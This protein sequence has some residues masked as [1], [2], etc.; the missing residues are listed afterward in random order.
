MGSNP[1]CPSCPSSPALGTQVNAGKKG[2]AMK[3][4]SV[5][6][7]LTIKQLALF[8]DKSSNKT[9]IN[10][11]NFT[12]LNNYITNGSS[13]NTLST[14]LNSTTITSLSYDQSK[15]FDTTCGV[16]FHIE[17]TANPCNARCGINNEYYISY[18][19]IPKSLSKKVRFRPVVNLRQY[20]GGIRGTKVQIALYDTPRMD[21][22]GWPIGDYGGTTRKWTS[23]VQSISCPHNTWVSVAFDDPMTGYENL[24]N[25]TAAYVAIGVEDAI[26]TRYTINFTFV[27]DWLTVV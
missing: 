15:D 14:L 26:Y 3:M 2:N 13:V 23:S 25:D 24:S 4:V 9:S 18:V 11:L 5:Q 8:L 19:N 1:S 17:R 10:N 20:S 22:Y 6:V 12:T 21:C 16:R 7:P 27:I